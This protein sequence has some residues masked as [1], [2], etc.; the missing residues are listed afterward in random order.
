[1]GIRNRWQEPW[2]NLPVESA[3]RQLLLYESPC[4][5]WLCTA[6]VG[7]YRIYHATVERFTASLLRNLALAILEEDQRSRSMMWHSRPADHG[8]VDARLDMTRGASGEA[9]N[10]TITPPLATAPQSGRLTPRLLAHGQHRH[11]RQRTWPSSPA[12][13]CADSS[14]SMGARVCAMVAHD[15][16]MKHTACKHSGTQR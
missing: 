14:C 13:Q 12:N 6:L 2:P 3:C 1:M 16:G 4:V 10:S 8:G 5:P 11:K 7:Y 15:G 9:A